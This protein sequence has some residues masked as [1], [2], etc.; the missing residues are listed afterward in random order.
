MGFQRLVKE[1]TVMSAAV[2]FLTANSTKGA[3]QNEV[4]LQSYIVLIVPNINAVTN[5]NKT[6]KLHNKKGR[7]LL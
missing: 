6:K 4:I 2:A 5:Q 7:S 3:E 1:A